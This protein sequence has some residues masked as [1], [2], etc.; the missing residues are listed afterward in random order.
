ME[1][2]GELFNGS[3]GEEQWTPSL[4]VYNEAVA[5]E[6]GEKIRGKIFEGNSVVQT[7]A[8]REFACLSVQ[9]PS[10]RGGRL[11]YVINQR[12]VHC[13]RISYASL[14]AVPQRKYQARTTPMTRNTCTR[15]SRSYRSIRSIRTP[16]GIFRKKKLNF[17]SSNLFGK[18][19]SFHPLFYGK[20]T[21]EGRRGEEKKEKRK[22]FHPSFI[23]VLV[24]TSI[25]ISRRISNSRSRMYIGYKDASVSVQRAAPVANI[26]QG[27]G[28]PVCAGAPRE[29]RGVYIHAY[30]CMYMHPRYETHWTTLWRGQ[31]AAVETVC[32]ANWFSL[33]SSIRRPR[34]PLR[35]P[36]S[37]AMEETSVWS[38]I[39]RS[40]HWIEYTRFD[41]PGCARRIE[42]GIEGWTID[43]SLDLG[44]LREIGGARWIMDRR[45]DSWRIREWN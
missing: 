37:S 6:G 12:G 31:T 44:D 19:N 38:S 34:N 36:S 22:T 24:I 25:S 33:A 14:R 42:R 27:R 18:G 5:V 15:I 4:D 8:T 45:G 26:K 1:N 11:L 35:A 20:L 30:V 43:R 29:N 16:L 32:P 9:Q 13:A 39:D 41:Y 7:R 40:T 3:E 28:G 10:L 23:H 17:S 21:Y 2:C